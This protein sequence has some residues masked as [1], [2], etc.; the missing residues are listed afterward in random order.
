MTKRHRGYYRELFF[1]NWGLGPYRCY[2][3]QELVTFDEVLV[4]HLDHDQLN[5]QIQNLMPVHASCHTSHHGRNR[6]TYVRDEAH[7]RKMSE[8]KM[9][10]TL[11]EET[12]RKISE[13]RKALNLSPVNKGKK[14]TEETRAKMRAAWDDRRQRAKDKSE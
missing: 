1:A 10:Q 4:H 3:C 9:G 11:S 14:H 7:R 5:D 2:F 6:A 8:A 12:R 13:T